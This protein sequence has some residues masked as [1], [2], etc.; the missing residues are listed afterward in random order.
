MT[1]L[2]LDLYLYPHPYP[3]LPAQACRPSAAKDSEQVHGQTKQGARAQ[4]FDEFGRLMAKA[5]VDARHT[6]QDH[7]PAMVRPGRGNPNTVEAQ[8]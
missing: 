5:V 1:A 6:P 3:H 7:P 2:D 4:K 8:S